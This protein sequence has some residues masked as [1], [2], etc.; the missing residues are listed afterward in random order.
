MT[1]NLTMNLTVILT[2][3]TKTYIEQLD[4]RFL[5]NETKGG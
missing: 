2:I 5:F 4:I 3:V 1:T